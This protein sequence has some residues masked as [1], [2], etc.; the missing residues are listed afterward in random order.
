MQAFHEGD[1][2]EIGELPKHMAHFTRGRA[3]V[4]HSYLK[5]YGLSGMFAF[6]WDRKPKP[7]KYDLWIL[8]KGSCAWYPEEVLTKV[9][10]DEGDR[11]LMEEMEKLIPPDQWKEIPR[12]QA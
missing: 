8:G 1:I 11:L 10:Y 4:L 2:V 5:V 9:G 7:A 6:G 3:I 12:E